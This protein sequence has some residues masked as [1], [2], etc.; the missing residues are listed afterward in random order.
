MRF[1]PIVLSLSVAPMALFAE[2]IPLRADISKV[3]LYPTGGTVTREVVVDVPQGQHELVLLDLP[4]GTDL[5]SVRVEVEGATLG[6]LTTRRDYVPPRDPA[7]SEAIEA[8]EAEVERLEAEL[9][10]ARAGIE[11]IRLEQEAAEARVAFLA[12]LGRGEG[13]AQMDPSALR[14]LVGLVG[15]ETL[16]AKQAAQAARLRAE[17]AERDLK[18]LNEALEAAREA[19]SALVPQE[20]P[21]AMLAVGIEA[22]AA[23]D[24]RVRLS[25]MVYEAGWSPVYDMRLD[26]ESGALEIARGAYVSQASGENWEG[27]DLTLSTVRPAE[28]TEP[29]EVHPWRRWITDKDTPQPMRKTLQGASADSF[30]RAEMAMEPAPSIVAEAEFDGLSVTYDYPRTLSLASGADR[31]RV[32]LG[33]LTTS[34][35]TYARAVPL[36]DSSAFL[37]ADLTNDTGEMILPGVVM[38]YLDGKFVGR[39]HSALVPA[40]GEADISFG[41]IDGLRLVRRIEDRQEGDRGVIRKSNDMNEAVRIEVENL[42]GEDWPVRLRDRVPYSEQEQL[43]ISWEAAPRVTEQDVDGERGVLEWHFDLSAG[44]T[45]VVKLD[46]WL[47]WPEDKVLR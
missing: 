29:S 39:G 16:S 41:P 30:A 17:A 28:Q 46:Q 24:V 36:A 13:V 45:K 26:R 6:A 33:T 43:E 40:G 8:A 18:D 44:E 25:H 15:D 35:E 23:S 19:L 37:M 12:A 22:E 3:T 38:K 7:K 27:V 9:R 20:G 32:D 5:D 34:T 1:L 10:E 11:G 4:R 31:V 21:H 14:E 42:T 47:K 2:D